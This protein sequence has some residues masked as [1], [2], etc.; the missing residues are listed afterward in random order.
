[1][2]TDQD[3]EFFFLAAVI[4]GALVG[5]T[6]AAI[7]GGNFGDILKGALIG[8]FS[9][10]VTYGIGSAFAGT[11]GIL[12]GVA[13]AGAHG[14]FQGMMSVA[15][16]GNF[17]Q[18]AAAGAFGSGFAHIGQGLGMAAQAGL[19]AIGGGIGAAIT[20]GNIWE[21]AV[22]G[23]M[24]GLLNHGLHNVE[25]GNGFFNNIPK[26][27]KFSY[28]MSD[29]VMDID[30]YEIHGKRYSWE[31]IANTWD[32]VTNKRIQQLDPRL[33]RPATQFINQVESDL[34]VQLR[35]TQG[36]RSFAEQNRL[37]AQGRT[38]HGRI[39]TNARGGQSYHNYGLAFDVVIM[40]NGQPVWK[41]LPANVGAMGTNLGF[42][43]G[44]NW[45]SFKDYPHFQMT[46]GQS[47]RQLK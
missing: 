2:Y 8:A 37:Y 42:E 41:P 35:I 7:H 4:I 17:W 27:P 22:I 33:Q 34:G 19:G 43:W 38:T 40:Q 31:R 47:V 23:G 32:N 15:Q 6:T 45:Q 26:P 12:A 30:G 14:L 13:E 11:T 36:Y 20:G 10:A 25:E 29:I 18:G 1:M 24:V 16:G 44:G 39:V 5:G 46:F 3:G 21:G 9:A 28:K